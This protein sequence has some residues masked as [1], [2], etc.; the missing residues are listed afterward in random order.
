MMPAVYSEADVLKA[1]EV[2]KALTSGEIRALDAWNQKKFAAEDSL[3]QFVEQGWDVLEP[4]TKFIPGM[5]VDAVCLH[6]QALI[7]DRL[8]DLI[9]NIPPGFAKS[10]I[11]AVF[12][13]AWVWI[14]RPEYR[15]LYSSYKA[16]YAVRDSVKCRSLIQS[17]WYQ[18]RWKDKFHLK[19]DQNE[20]GKFENDKTGYRETTSV[21]TG[22]GARA[23]LVCCDDP[24]SVDQAASDA[25]RN[26]ANAWWT[27][28]MTTRLNDLR[29]GHLLLIQQR[30]HEEDTTAVSVEQGGYE[31][32]YLPN[33]FEVDRACVTHA[34]DGAEL[35]KDPRTKEGQLL[36]PA[37][38]GPDEVAML[39]RKLGSYGYSGQYQQRP[40]PSGGGIFKK[41]WWRYWTYKT[42]SVP[43]VL[44][45][46]ADGTM[47]KIVPV[48]LP[49]KFD[50]QVQSWDMAFKDLSTS[51]YV[52]GGVWGTKAAD[53]YLLDQTRERLGF[54]ETVMAVKKMSKK[55]PEAGLKLVEDKANGPAVIQSLRHEIPGLVPI[56]P[57]GGKVARAQAVSPQVES[58]NVYLPHPAIA[59][60]VEAFVEECSTFPNGKYDDQ[61]DQMTQ[62]LNRLR[63]MV[64]LTRSVLPP[65]RPPSGDRGWMA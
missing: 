64:N 45:R 23:M 46:L 28:T 26:R 60:W 9:I 31:H 34:K 6:L 51:D 12:F 63:A 29:T 15:F 57:D 25:E 56:V 19:S 27:G 8:K 62:A 50:S 2:T 59:P 17:G 35:W 44:V 47:Q 38:V 65:P 18:D 61:V 22:T 11:A 55:W 49:D 32:L 40:S 1:L 37:K 42:I 13:P 16:E 21:A 52:A 48:I 30:L 5:H 53:R 10:M 14:K 58:G 7:E 3:R 41:Q 36:W 39:K 43:P 4:G 33:E 54:P 24:T 20:K